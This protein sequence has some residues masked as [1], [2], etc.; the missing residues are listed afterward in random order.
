MRYRA[1]GRSAL[2]VKEL[3]LDTVTFADDW[4]WCAAIDACQNVFAVYVGHDCPPEAF[5]GHSV[6]RPWRKRRW[7]NRKPQVIVEVI[8]ASRYMTRNVF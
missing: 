5:A 6:H 8:V 7:Q 4:G 3:F 1:L 2:P